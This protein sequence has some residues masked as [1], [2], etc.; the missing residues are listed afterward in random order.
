MEK[1]KFVW[2]IDSCSARNGRKLVKGQ[3]YKVAD[4]DPAVVETWV[5]TKA[6]KYSTAKS[7]EEEKK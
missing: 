3:S 5:K 2:L 1:S 6:A 7:A 4:F